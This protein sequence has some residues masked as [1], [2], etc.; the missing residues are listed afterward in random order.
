MRVAIS[1]EGC[2]PAALRLP[3]GPTTFD[4]TARESSKVTEFELIA[5][6]RTIAEAENLV[7]GRTGRFSLTL[8]PGRY[9]MACPGGPA[10]EPA[11]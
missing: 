10:R 8:Q 2:E 11:P 7:E 5:D 6:G 1:A 9:T 4:V 3:A